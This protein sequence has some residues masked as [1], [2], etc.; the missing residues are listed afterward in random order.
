VDPYK[1][2]EL[3]DAIVKV[4]SSKQ[5]QASMREKGIAQ[6]KKFSWRKCSEA[7]HHHLLYGPEKENTDQGGTM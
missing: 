6:A 4:L 1:V 2:E 3:R 5:L 7:V